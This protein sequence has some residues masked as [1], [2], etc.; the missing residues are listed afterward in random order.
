MWPRCV[1][2]AEKVVFSIASLN[3]F[4]SGPFEELCGPHC[5][6]RGRTE[7]QQFSSDPSV[8]SCFCWGRLE[9]VVFLNHVLEAAILGWEARLCVFYM[10]FDA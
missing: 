3:K 1:I 4:D 10:R 6:F 8:A 2:F 5:L 9:G 7:L